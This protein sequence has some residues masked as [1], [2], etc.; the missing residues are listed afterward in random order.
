MTSGATAGEGGDVYTR[1]YVA[2][3][4]IY[5]F[6]FTQDH[7]YVKNGKDDESEANFYF[8]PAIMIEIGRT[9]QQMACEDRH[10]STTNSILSSTRLKPQDDASE[11]HH[12]I[13]D[14]RD[15]VPLCVFGYHV[16][17]EQPRLISIS[18]ARRIPS[19]HS[20]P[21]FLPTRLYP[22]DLIPMLQLCPDSTTSI[23]L[24]GQGKVPLAVASTHYALF[25]MHFACP[26]P[27]LA[28][29]SGSRL[30]LAPAFSSSQRVASHGGQKATMGS[31]P[32]IS[33]SA[34][35][36]KS[37]ASKQRDVCSNSPKPLQSGLRSAADKEVTTP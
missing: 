9:A 37:F 27:K 29:G 18:H 33:R 1:I 5:C 6:S 17:P 36:G 8:H 15:N 21:Q 23:T 28:G 13:T 26:T 10:A 4:R 24:C 19:H 34:R 32:I 35:S 14:V 11:Q 16:Y 22:Q 20:T 25:P 2:Q 3:Y 31:S 7:L 30:L 12:G